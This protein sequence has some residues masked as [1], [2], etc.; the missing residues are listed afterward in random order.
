MSFHQDRQAQR[1]F[2]VTAA[3]WGAALLLACA[4]SVLCAGSLHAALLEREQS[5]AASLLEQGVSP[6]AITAALQCTRPSPAAEALLLRLGR[7]PRT[8]FWLLP[9][10]RAHAWRFLLAAGFGAVLLSACQLAAAR[11]FLS[12][13]DRMYRE[14]AGRMRRFA[15]GDFTCR[16]P[17][18]QDGALYQLFAAAEQL[19]TALQSKINAEQRSKEFL[20]NMFSDISHQLKTPLAALQMY[21]EIIT[22]EPDN[23]ETISVF[24][25]KS[26]ASIARMESLIGTLLKIAR[27]DAGSISFAPETMLA[28]DLAAK[29]AAELQTR[30]AREGKR[31]TLTGDRAL[32]LCCDPAWTAEALGNLIK[33]ALDHTSPGD[34]ITVRWEQSP[35]MLCITVAD[36]G[37]GIAPADLH[38]IFKRFYR[39]P[40]AQNA[41]G[42]GLGLP[43]A[44]AVIEGQGGMLSVQ[45]APHQGAAFTAAFLV[46]PPLA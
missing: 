29:A 6:T 32:T 25:E 44:R 10:V 22:A 37:E 28:A 33:N 24:T 42:T 12:M 4:L 35:A 23:A 13:R 34:E 30:A 21:A 14:A 31:L 26:L 15:D 41:Q 46:K 7:S 8:P 17:H 5:L 40:S 36:T 27:L 45:S 3:L 16:L 38:H 18:A 39:S 2:T 20:K 11:R 43:L 19:S 1:F 9:S